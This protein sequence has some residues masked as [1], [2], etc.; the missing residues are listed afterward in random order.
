MLSLESPCQ[1][2]PE[3]DEKAEYFPDRD[4]CKKKKK[5]PGSW[6]AADHSAH[7]PSPGGCFGLVTYFFAK[8]DPCGSWSLVFPFVQ[9]S[10]VLARL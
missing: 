6:V 9:R 10:V 4:L 5:V 2:F 8:S 3:S 1:A 7:A